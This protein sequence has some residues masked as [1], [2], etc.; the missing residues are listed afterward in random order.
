ME[1]DLVKTSISFNQHVPP[2]CW[3]Y[4]QPASSS[5]KLLLVQSFQKGV[6]LAGSSK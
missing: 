6:K 4:H 3:Q 1:A 2:D 5:I